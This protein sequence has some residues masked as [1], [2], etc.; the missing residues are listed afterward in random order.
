MR[1]AMGLYGRP[2]QAGSTTGREDRANA[3]GVPPAATGPRPGKD[4]SAKPGAAKKVVTRAARR[5]H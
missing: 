3:G 2:R 1:G 5:P 4:R